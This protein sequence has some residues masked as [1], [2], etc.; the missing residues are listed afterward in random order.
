MWACAKEARSFVSAWPEVSQRRLD[1]LLLTGRRPLFTEVST[2][3]WMLF[4]LPHHEL[5]R[6]RDALTGLH[7][8]RRPT[9]RAADER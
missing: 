3:R 1:S 8:I 9:C 4:A 7:S 6:T 2:R 5:I